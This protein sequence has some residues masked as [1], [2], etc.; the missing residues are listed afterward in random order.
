[1]K[2]KFFILNVLIWVM[3]LT[4][5]NCQDD[6]Q[7]NQIGLEGITLKKINKTFYSGPDSVFL[8]AFPIN[9]S[10]NLFLY[11]FPFTSKTNTFNFHKSRFDEEI[12]LAEYDNKP[13]N[14]LENKSN[15]NINI[16]SLPY[17][18][19][20]RPAALMP[21]LKFKHESSIPVKILT[22]IV[23]YNYPKLISVTQI[24][25]NRTYNFSYYDKNR[26]PRIGEYNRGPL[27]K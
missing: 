21:K 5:A 8:S 11:T 22:S 19:N 3:F 27:I 16:T 24:L 6:K 13:I 14:G 20:E 26:M 1:M 10:E 7:N 12:G 18:N 2:I 25:D 17:F 4:K 9:K 15:S 23:K